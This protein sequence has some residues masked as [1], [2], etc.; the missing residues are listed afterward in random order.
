MIRTLAALAVVVGLAATARAG[1]MDREAIGGPA[2]R[3]A[4]A[5]VRPTIVTPGTEMDAETPEQSWCRRGWGR[6]GCWGGCGW[7][8]GRTTFF[9]PGWGGGWARPCGWGGCGWTSFHPGWHGG[10]GWGRPGW[11][12]GCW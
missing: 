6:G 11:G 1:E 8:W 7:G 5:V 12:G 9:A 2:I 4:V 3:S 10:W